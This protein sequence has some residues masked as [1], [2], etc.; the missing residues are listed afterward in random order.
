MLCPSRSLW[1][2]GDVPSAI[3]QQAAAAIATGAAKTGFNTTGATRP[4]PGAKAN[5]TD[6]RPDDSGASLQST[7]K[8]ASTQRQVT[9]LKPS[10][11]GAVLAA[12][13]EP[14]TDNPPVFSGSPHEH[15]AAGATG[16]AQTDLSASGIQAAN[17][18]QQPQ[19]TVIAPN[20]LNV[21]V[22]TSA[23]VPLNALALQIAATA[24]NGKSR[25]EIRLD[26]AELGRIDVRIDI[27]RQGQMTSHLTVEK[28]ETLTMLRQDAPQLQR[29]LDDAGF[30]TGDGG[31]QFSLRDQSSSGQNS[32]NE[33]TRHG[34]RLLI[35]NEET[36]SATTAGRTYGR[37][38]A[39]SGGVDIR[40]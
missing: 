12:K 1:P 34:Q 27:D 37:A 19:S 4:S 33:S 13:P 21:T 15:I 3:E 25:F 22:A 28:P 32:G 8:T 35:G 40:V 24:Q 31:L 39:S 38:L 11:D 5:S 30:K 2:S 26:P 6:F 10:A 29:A 16:P 9:D 14:S 23:P 36:I 20:Q 18:L 7:D 17:N